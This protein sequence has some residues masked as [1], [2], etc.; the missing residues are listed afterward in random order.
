[1]DTYSSCDSQGGL[2]ASQLRSSRG[3]MACCQYKIEKGEAI[4]VTPLDES[5]LRNIQEALKSQVKNKWSKAM[6]EEVDPIKWN[7]V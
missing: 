3:V 6:H 5:E 2:K 4:M 1:M 7:Q